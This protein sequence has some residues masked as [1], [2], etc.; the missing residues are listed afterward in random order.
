MP[1]GTTGWRPRAGRSVCEFGHAVRAN[2]PLPTPATRLSRL[3]CREGHGSTRR[4]G[5]WVERGAPPL[6][7]PP[8]TPREEGCRALSVPQPRACAAALFS[9]PAAM[10]IKKDLRKVP[11]ILEDE[12]DRREQLKLARRCAAAGCGGGG[13]GAD[14][15]RQRR[16]VCGLHADTC[17]LPLRR[18]LFADAVPLPVQ[19]RA[20]QPRGGR[21]AALPRNP[22]CLMP[23]RGTPQ[24]IGA[25][26]GAPLAELN[27]GYNLLR[28]IS[29]QV[30]APARRRRGGRAQV[31]APPLAP[32]L[33]QLR[34]LKRLSV[35]DN[36]LEV[37][38]EVGP[39]PGTGEARRAPHRAAPRPPRSCWSSEGWRRCISR[40]TDSQSSQSPSPVSRSSGSWCG[41]APL[42]F[43]PAARH[44]VSAPRRRWSGTVSPAC[45]APS[46]R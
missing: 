25:L 6:T 21:G 27:L 33:A 40:A 8:Q 30:R 14:A 44:S 13:A 43:P 34:S 11:E 45:P 22:A 3:C 24:G 31:R 10:F 12:D 7:P 1:R 15:G 46:S 23:V 19:Q 18:Q 38:P 36:E 20:R 16:R 42:G 39:W 17:A 5:P 9:A 37:F 2:L 28:E 29:P 26:E 35:E 32:Q 41:Q 4:P